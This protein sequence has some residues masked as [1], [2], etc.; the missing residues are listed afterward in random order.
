MAELQPELAIVCRPRLRQRLEPSPVGVAVQHKVSGLLRKMRIALN[1]AD[2]R[3]GDAAI[4][5][6]FVEPQLGIGWVAGPIA[7]RVRHCRFGDAILENKA[8][9]QLHGFE[10]HAAIIV[11]CHPAPRSFVSR[12]R[13]P[14]TS[15]TTQFDGFGVD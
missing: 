7:K 9:W 14:R 8:A 1:L 6:A 2:D 4:D 5:P 11:V 10:Q 3:Q 15:I 13:L 12:V